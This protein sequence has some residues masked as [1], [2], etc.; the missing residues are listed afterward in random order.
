MSGM[1][2]YPDQMP[3]AATSD[4]CLHCLLGIQDDYS[5]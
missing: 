4:V 3:H 5:V 2:V 1:R